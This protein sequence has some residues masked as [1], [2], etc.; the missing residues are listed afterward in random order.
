[1]L[2][3]FNYHSHSLFCD[4]K[5]TMEDMVL[6]A[7][8]KGLHYFGFS[9]HSP[10]CFESK[11]ALKKERVE[12]Y[13]S[14]AKF[15]KEK[16]QDKI[17]LFISMEMDYINSLQENI[18]EMSKEY[19]LDYFIGSV[20]FVKGKTNDK[21]WFIDGSNRE[22]YDR[23]LEEVFGG[24]I[25]EG[26]EAYFEQVINMVKSQRPDVVGHFDKIKMHN[27][28]RFFSQK[29]KWFEDFMMQ[30]L[31]TIKESGSICEIN[32]RGIYKKRCDDFYPGRDWIKK[33][34]EMKIPLTIS[35]DCHKKDEVDLLFDDAIE[36]LKQIGERYVWYF[37]GEW[38]AQKII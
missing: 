17:K 10:L 13:L 4:G 27:N 30:T 15:L 29:D 37:D 34:L 1:M 9:S 14:T 32:T 28:E 19:D 3:K 24:N 22:V 7:I 38:K 33:A 23:G 6:S 20:H 35:T 2:K 18:R 16:Y 11:V 8:D 31:E 5:D 12:E 26:V 21:I 36:Y 25:R